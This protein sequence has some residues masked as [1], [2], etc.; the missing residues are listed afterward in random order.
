MAFKE[1][2]IDRRYLIKALSYY[3]AGIELLLA[4]FFFLVLLKAQ[5]L[6]NRS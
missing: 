4:L 6:K 5:T 1:L 3:L 2:I